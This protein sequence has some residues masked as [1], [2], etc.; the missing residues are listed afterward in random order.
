MFLVGKNLQVE[1][2][3]KTSFFIFIF[4]R[5]MV[6]KGALIR[7]VMSAVLLLVSHASKDCWPSWL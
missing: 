2:V 7:S 4:K 5:K 6:L 3:E 1:I